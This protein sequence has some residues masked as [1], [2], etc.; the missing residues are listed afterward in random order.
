MGYQQA[1]Q[2]AGAT[3]AG[4]PNVDAALQLRNRQ[5]NQTEAADLQSLEIAVR[6]Q[7]ERSN[8]STGITNDNNMHDATAVKVPN[9]ETLYLVAAG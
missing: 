5:Q 2:A 3:V 8:L 4:E 6:T 1:L 9:S 7:A